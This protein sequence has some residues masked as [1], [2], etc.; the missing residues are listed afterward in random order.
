MSQRYREFR[1]V[2]MTR[3]CDGLAAGR[4]ENCRGLLQALVSY[5][6]TP[7]ETAR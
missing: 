6:P 7:G 2:L 5:P 4:M 3:L 1:R